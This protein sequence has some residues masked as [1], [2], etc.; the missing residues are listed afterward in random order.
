MLDI[1]SK[2]D[3]DDTKL[4]SKFLLLRDQIAL[5]PERAMLENWTKGFKD[6]DGKIIKEFQT[7]F[8]SSF[9]EFFL[10]AVFKEAQLHV[11]FSSTRP[12]FLI[13]EQKAIYLEA[14]VANIKKDGRS[15]EKR[16]ISDVLSMVEPF[17]FQADF[18]EKINEAATRYSNAIQAKSQK[19]HEYSQD[20]NF[21]KNSCYIV[22]L[23]GHEQVNYGNTFYFPMLTLLYGYSYDKF[24]HKFKKINKVVKPNTTA[25]IP[26]GLF[27]NEDFSHISA[28]IFTNTLTLGKLKSLTISNGK[29]SFDLNDVICIRHDFEFPHFKIQLV[30]QEVP[31]ELTDGIFILHNP[32]A[33]NSLPTGFLRD[34]NVTHITYDIVNEGIRCEG[35]SL[36]IVSRLNI[37]FGKQYVKGFSGCL[38]PELLI[39]FAKVTFI[40]CLSDGSSDVIFIDVEDEIEFEISFSIEKFQEYEIEENELFAL[41]FYS[42]TS[43]AYCIT[44]IE[45]Y[46]FICSEG[47]KKVNCLIQGMGQIIDIQKVN[48]E[49]K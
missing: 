19:F 6:R 28:I 31:E 14:V 37:M 49:L 44:T 39:V 13:I 3:I 48:A 22:A 4:H 16:S 47:V 9:W 7:T 23:S 40:E 15:E 12:D 11:N 45:Q 29:D 35:N 36:P 43:D 1:F 10:F 38:N 33:T 34:T 27:A 24:N 46:R 21:E 18:D 25:Q 8:H 20:P 5:S 42:D 41:W 32:Y 17:A 2:I 30:S 26:V